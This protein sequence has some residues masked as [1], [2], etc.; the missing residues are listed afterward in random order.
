MTNTSRSILSPTTR[1]LVVTENNA[2]ANFGQSRRVPQLAPKLNHG[3]HRKNRP[4]DRLIRWTIAP[5]ARIRLRLL[6]I[7]AA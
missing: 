7:M 5:G 1:I 3:H 4:A 2:P 6:D